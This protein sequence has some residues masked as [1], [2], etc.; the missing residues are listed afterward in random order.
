M[1][2]FVQVGPKIANGVGGSRATNLLCI[3]NLMSYLY[4]VP[5]VTIIAY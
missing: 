5:L 4:A 1:S 3:T 2:I